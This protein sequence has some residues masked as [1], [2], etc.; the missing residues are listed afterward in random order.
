MP[1]TIAEDEY[2]IVDKGAANPG[3]A[4]VPAPVQVWWP[5]WVGADGTLRTSDLPPRGRT[6]ETYE[7]AVSAVTGAAHSPKHVV[8]IEFAHVFL[9][10]QR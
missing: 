10:S 9:L 6:A 2:V 8:V 1:R 4:S 3:D 7:V 5:T